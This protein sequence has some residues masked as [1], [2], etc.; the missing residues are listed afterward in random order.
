M[1]VPTSQQILT[2]SS[3][4]GHEKTHE[5]DQA[6]MD[7]KYSRL[8]DLLR[9]TLCL[10]GEIAE[11]EASGQR[12][13]GPSAVLPGHTRI[14]GE[15]ILLRKT[16]QI[17]SE[18]FTERSR[19]S[20]SR[21][22]RGSSR[23]SVFNESGDGSRSA[24]AA[25][26]M[27]EP[28]SPGSLAMSLDAVVEGEKSRDLRCFENSTSLA[29]RVA[30]S[31]PLTR[32]TTSH[33]SMSESVSAASAPIPI[34][35]RPRRRPSA[36]HRE[37]SRSRDYK[38]HVRI[39]PVALKRETIV[40]SSPPNTPVPP[41]F[42]RLEAVFPHCFFS[43]NNSAA[44]WSGEGSYVIIGRRPIDEDQSL[45]ALDERQ[46]EF[47]PAPERCLRDLIDEWEYAVDETADGA[48]ARQEDQLDD[49]ARLTHTESR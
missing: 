27:Q 45:L 33:E 35:G 9:K 36:S 17:P 12:T 46:H 40:P 37:A 38:W 32:V 18:P 6:P 7:E 49:A 48:E 26:S 4:A 28:F 47:G 29:D 39:V 31:S 43:D 13:C 42:V 21:L 19:R 15:C 23:R 2:Q 25:P 10:A 11:E 16:L 24:S 41:G 34:P 3:T 1:Y 22:P 8:E 20:S 14:P 30:D 44:R 5:T